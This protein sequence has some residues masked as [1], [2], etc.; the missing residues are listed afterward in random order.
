MIPF[1]DAQ[2][3][4]LIDREYFSFVL[5]QVKRARHKIWVSLFIY[6]IRPSRDLEGLVLD[7][8]AALIERNSLGVDVK[9][10]LNGIATTPDISVANLASGL[11]LTEFGIQH[12]RV[13]D[14]ENRSG[15]HA[16]FLICDDLAVIGSQNWTDD[17]FRLN[18]EDAIILKSKPVMILEREFLRLWEVGRGLPS[19]NL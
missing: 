8:T 14:N 1:K 12:R 10:L 9:V 19:Q 16:K 2:V 17:G 13:F 15:S 4:S 3:K 11:Y 7:L 6:D 5:S 18:I